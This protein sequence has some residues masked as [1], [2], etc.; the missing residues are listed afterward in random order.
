MENRDKEYIII[1]SARLNNLKNVSLKI[2]K[3]EV[4]VFSGVS[5][6][7]KS[8]IVFDT[9]AVESQRQLN[10]TF[11]SFI[12]NRLPKY[13]RPDVKSISNLSPAIVIDQKQMGG[14]IRSTVGTITDIQPL[15]RLLFSRAGIPSAG[16]SNR[17][18]FND[19]AGMCPHCQGLGKAI[20]LDMDRL[21]DMDKSLNNGA[22]LFPPFRT[23]T[24]HWQK[25]ANSGFFDNDKP[26]KDYTEEEMNIFL[27]AKGIKDVKVPITL[28]KGIPT[29]QRMDYEG[30][31]DRFNRIYLNRPAGEISDRTISMVSKFVSEGICPVCH[32]ER[33]NKAA[34]SSRINGYNISDYSNMEISDLIPILTQIDDKLGTPVALSI[35]ENLKRIKGVGLGYLSLS[36]ETSTLSGGESQRL[37]MVKHLGSSLTGMTYIFD[38]PS[39][40][41]HPRDI[42]LLKDMF[43][44]LRDKG[45]S[46]LIVEHDKDIIS[47]ADTLID[48]GPMAGEHGGEVVYQGDVQGL[49]KADTLTAEMMNREIP[50][51]DSVNHPDSWL[52]IQNATLHNLKNISVK[53]PKGVLTCI[54]GV[55]GSGKSSL[56]SN[57]FVEQYPEAIEVSQKAIRGSTRSNSATYL[58]IMDDI[59]KMF[60]A[61][62]NVT[63]GMFSFNSEGA[64]P[65]CNGRGVITSDMAFMETVTTICETCQGK[66][67]KQEVLKYKLRGKSITD[68]LSLTITQS[69]DFFSKERFLPKLK[70][71]DNVGLGYLTLGQSLDTLSG[72]ELQRVKLAN[73]LKKTGNIYVMDEPTT[74][75]HM[76]DITVL[77]HLLNHLVSNGNT[78]IVIEHNLDVI[79]QADWIIDMGP[80]GG[81]RGGEILFEGT[82]KELIKVK[83]SLTAKYLLKSL[84]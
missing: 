10:D 8:S 16:T 52:E 57:V 65:S 34:L 4:V 72:G 2:P 83:N 42:G 48:M 63:S 75:L 32:G 38:E 29:F 7:G 59:R 12:R 58:G 79:K 74:G 53:I 1:E 69:L 82:P 9:V 14:N 39:V 54:T 61:K 70:S 84:K 45:N 27:Y 30:I 11:S 17:Y 37:K 20:A 41:L 21:F 68:V 18:S 26:L 67:Y 15:V 66:K 80:D 64:C 56:I 50:L 44:A 6:S 81:K 19:P 33:L 24:W 76:A 49:Y 43:V 51:K 47:H 36:R 25:Y 55:A 5:G 23:G 46:V 62:N 78:V 77:M 28:G 13:E 71:L 40:G 31:I 3:N 73:E 35:T 22:I 60:A